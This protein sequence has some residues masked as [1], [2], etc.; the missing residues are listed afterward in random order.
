MPN[1]NRQIDAGS[2]CSFCAAARREHKI[3][4]RAGGQRDASAPVAGSGVNS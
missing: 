4:L 1:L 3:D 2:S